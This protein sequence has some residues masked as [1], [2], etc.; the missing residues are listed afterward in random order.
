LTLL[1]TPKKATTATAVVI[2]LLIIF[3]GRL[4]NA[5][6]V[7]SVPIQ[8]GRDEAKD[9]DSILRDFYAITM[10]SAAESPSLLARKRCGCNS[11]CFGTPNVI[12]K[13]KSLVPQSLFRR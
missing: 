3:V 8:L 10:N 5:L 12:N 1:N 13:L 9:K 7:F 4:L 6:S 11:E 2:R